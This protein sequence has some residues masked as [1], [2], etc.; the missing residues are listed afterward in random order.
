MIEPMEVTTKRLE[1]CSLVSDITAGGSHDAL[2]LQPV[3]EG[4]VAIPN[5]AASIAMVL[6]VA[7]MFPGSSRPTVAWYLL[8]GDLSVTEKCIFSSEAELMEKMTS[9]ERY[10]DGTYQWAPARY[11]DPGFPTDQ[12]PVFPHKF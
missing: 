2:I 12:I 7:K 4:V 5:Y 11:T 9:I 1:L 6:P 3:S 10:R 8:G